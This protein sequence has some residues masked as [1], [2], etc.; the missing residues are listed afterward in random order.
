[1]PCSVKLFLTNQES[2]ALR[3][4]VHADGSNNGKEHIWDLEEL[5]PFTNPIKVR[6]HNAI[7]CS[8]PNERETTNYYLFV[9]GLKLK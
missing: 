6:A 3:D 8:F 2:R 9:F 1:M 4:K 5:P 7:D